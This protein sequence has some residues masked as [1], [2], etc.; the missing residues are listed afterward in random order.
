ML[1]K[2]QPNQGMYLYAHDTT[3]DVPKTGDAANITGTAS[4][5]GDATPSAFATAHPV[6][7]GGGVYWQPLSQAETDGDAFAFAWSSSTAGVQID[8]ALGLTQGGAIPRAAAGA[9]GGLP[10]V[11]AGNR[12]AGVQAGGIDAASVAGGAMAGKGDWATA[13]DLGGLSTFDPAADPVTLA[14]TQPDYAPAKAGDAMSLTSAE[15]TTLAAA[16]FGSVVETGESL[17]QWCRKVRAVLYG[18]TD[19]GI[20][21]QTKFKRADGVTDS[22][23][24]AHDDA[25]G[26]SSVTDGTN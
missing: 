25:G 5:D 26:R 12:V 24:V 23:T 22:L 17:L 14:G 4:L 2:N 8:P 18:R 20:P 1:F 19:T 9:A 11:D 10:T 15:R 21:G 6:E 16:V 7:V 13:A 3:A